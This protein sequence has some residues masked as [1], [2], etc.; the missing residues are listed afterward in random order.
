MDTFVNYRNPVEPDEVYAPIFSSLREEGRTTLVLDLR[1]NGGGSND[2]MARLFAHLV[3]DAARL[4]KPSRIKTLDLDGLR[5]H[6][7]TWEKRAL[8]PKRW[9]FRNNDDGTYSPRWFLSDETRRIR[10]ARNAFTGRLIVLSGKDNSSGSTNLIAK[11]Q[12]MGR[13]T[14]VGEATGGSAEGPTAG[15][16]FF[17]TLPESGV[18]ARLPALRGYNDVRRFEQGLGVMPDVL[19]EVTADD[20]V[21]GRDAAMERA[22]AIAAGR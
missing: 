21:A 9:Q 3:G 13:A 16:L 10:P 18:V 1:R 20:F 8:N 4:H 14:V 15:V 2:A 19:V 7:D 22:L 11:L 5:A 6:L 17:L 12:D